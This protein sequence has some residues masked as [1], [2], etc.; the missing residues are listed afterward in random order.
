MTE[1]YQ[2]SPIAGLDAVRRMLGQWRG[3]RVALELPEGWL[4]LDTVAR[5]RLLERQAQIQNVELALITRH[6]PT[7]QA[8]K[9][10]GVPVFARTEDAVSRRWRMDP[11]YP[12][13]DPHNPHATLPDPP[14]WRRTDEVNRLAMPTHRQARQERIRKEMNY[15]KPLPTWLRWAGNLLMGALIVAILAGFTFYVLPAATV[16]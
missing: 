16:T 4:E 5:M 8:A 15:R 2:V 9:Q 6:D 1:V 13:I 10:V 7:R 14:P 11:P 12:L 3:K